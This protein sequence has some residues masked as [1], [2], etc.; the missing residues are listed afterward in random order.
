MRRRWPC[1]SVRL[2]LKWQD[3]P[4]ASNV[5]RGHAGGHGRRRRLCHSSCSKADRRMIKSLSLKLGML[6]IAIGVVFWIGLRTRRFN[7]FLR[8]LKSR[9]SPL[10]PR[11][12]KNNTAG[13]PVPLIRTYRVRS[14]VSHHT[15]RF[16][17]HST[18]IVQAP[19]S[20]SRCLGSVPYLL[21]V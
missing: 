9:S 11:N 7:L 18:S 1:R 15:R 20:L 3:D 6:S 2:C 8:I 17:H 16:I 13:L 4:Y 5:S 14:S 21:N 12:R 19:V 10:S